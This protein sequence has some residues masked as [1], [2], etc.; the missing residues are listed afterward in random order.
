MVMSRASQCVKKMLILVIAMTKNSEI[1]TKNVVE[2]IWS[3]SNRVFILTIEY[4]IFHIIYL[5]MVYPLNCMF[6]GHLI[7][8]AVSN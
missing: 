8:N 7:Q 6:S 3:A 5:S 2:I 1:L 4:G